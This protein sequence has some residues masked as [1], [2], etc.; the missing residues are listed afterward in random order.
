MPVMDTLIKGATVVLPHGPARVGVGI[1]DGVIVEIC[2]EKWLPDA[3]TIIDGAGKVLAPGFVDSHVH[4][5]GDHPEREDFASGSAA[6][7]MGGVTTI[8]EMPVVVPPV[9]RG[10]LLEQRAREAETQSIVDFGLYGGAGEDN[11]DEIG[12]LAEAGAV[13]FKTFLH[14]APAGREE[15]FRGLTVSNNA[16]LFSV[17]GRVS[18]TGLIAAVHAEDYELLESAEFAPGTV[19]S[20][21]ASYEKLRPS[22]VEVSAA[23]RALFFARRTGARLMLCHVSAPETVDMALQARYAGQEVLIETCPQY[24]LF[25]S[26]RIDSLG[27]FG[28]V[29][30]P[31]RDEATRNRLHSY[32][33]EGRFDFIGSDHAPFTSAEKERYGNNLDAAPSGL[34]G[35]E[36][37]LSLLLNEVSR[38]YMD[39]CSAVKLFSENAA[40]AFR[41]YPRKG[42]IAPGADADLVPFDLSRQQHIGRDALTTRSRHSGLIYEGLVLT[43]MPVLT[44]V[45][46]SIVMRDGVVVGEP[47]IGRFVRPVLGARDRPDTEKI[48]G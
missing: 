32:M 14:P 41:L 29:K 16:A 39:I 46:G 12:G 30:P 38:K 4:I 44:M 34:P 35:I 31:I 47:G 6:A 33:V 15:E 37:T 3:K 5:R 9:V 11:L 8:L 24:V 18:K 42:C 26:E 7:A 36:L 40:K 20:G 23:A 27:P 2:D 48:T 10:E 13:A 1:A 19:L 25:S 43:G 45:R 22:I 17:F 28:K 21:L